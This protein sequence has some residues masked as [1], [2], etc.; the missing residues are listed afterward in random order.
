MSR[1]MRD[2]EVSK[3][4]AVLEHKRTGDHDA[5]ITALM[6]LWLVPPEGAEQQDLAHTD[7]WDAIVE[8]NA[9]DAATSAGLR[10]AREGKRIRPAAFLDLSENVSKD[11]LLE[12]A[13][14]VVSSGWA[15]N[16]YLATVLVRLV[17][18]NHRTELNQLLDR[19]GESLRATEDGWLLGAFLLTTSRAGSTKD[20]ERWFEGWE[21]R[22][23]VP[24]WILA[25]YAA[26]IAHSARTFS[27]LPAASL[28]VLT[29]LA[30]A[31]C[32]RA[33][34][35]DS[36]AFFVH[37]RLV[38]HL[39]RGRVD[40][41]LADHATHRELLDRQSTTSLLDHPIAHY[42]NSLK[43]RYKLT[44]AELEYRRSTSVSP[45]ALVIVLEAVADARQGPRPVNLQLAEV[46]AELGDFVDSAGRL[47][48]LYVQLHEL[49]RG[50]RKAVELMKQMRKSRPSNL[51]WIRNAWKRLVR[52][53]V[54]WGKRV[55]FALSDLF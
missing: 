14:I 50:D 52:T 17:E 16:P 15:T 34:W 10:L 54:S 9:V 40:A 48:G 42:A 29:E 13:D 55:Q 18:Q 7:A 46:V 4:S 8:A 20:V 1:A 25:A 39:R 11:A 37:L 38:D 36:A 23:R 3:V 33:V 45:V 19:H 2:N 47:L 12:L 43:H 26:T 44:R 24:M 28:N 5:M 6:S 49:E 35:D 31:A 30:A 53:R 27:K 22:E 51:P 21:R 32:E 41:F